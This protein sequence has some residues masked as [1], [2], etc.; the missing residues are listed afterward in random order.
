M[1]A[2]LERYKEFF[3]VTMVR[4]SLSSSPYASFEDSLAALREGLAGELITSG[5]P[6]FDEAR[7]M[8]AFTTERHP[9]AIV[10]AANE[11]DVAAAVNFAREH[12]L[13]LSVRS[14]GHSI[15]HLSVIDGAVV[16]DLSRM[17]G[18]RIDPVA[19]IGR[20]QAG[21]TSFDLAVP[22]NEHGLAL[23][24]GDTQ[25]VG[26]GG[27][28]TGGGIGFMV[29]KY[30]LAIDNLLSARVVLADG[31]IVTASPIERPDLF[32]A[33]RGGGGNVGIVT[34]FTY[35][36]A[37][38]GTILGGELMLPATREVLRGYL[39]YA[40][41]APEDLTTIANLVYA[42]PFPHV[43]ADRVGEMVLSILVVW[44]GSEEEGNRAL[45][46]LR[47]LAEPVADAIGMIPYPQIYKFTEHV[48]VRH[49][50][51]IRQMFAYD[52]SDDVVDAAL[53]AMK[54]ASS[55]F[56]L[57]QFRGLGGS[58]AQVDSNETAF[59][60]RDKTFFLAIIA[61]WLDPSEDRAAHDA[62]TLA[63]W[64][65]VRHEGSGVYVNF[66]ENE[67]EERIRQAYPA[68]TYARLA[69]IKRHYDPDNLFRFNQNIPPRQGQVEGGWI[70][71]SPLAPTG[72]KRDGAEQLIVSSTAD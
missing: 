66:L 22:A 71:D 37:P 50:A 13:P 55:P 58:M 35:R 28:T 15:A 64:E 3:M 56:S 60:H 59:A 19:R 40:A 23:S 33:I 45:A 43:P 2:V 18:V 21:A 11:Y 38:V 69:K 48:A 41:T 54:N 9:A 8:V 20:V 36:L 34:E 65:K 32:W 52:L 4:S 6:Q 16:V 27:L 72:A 63:L 39:D 7:H 46:P 51:A 1:T 70:E 47:A 42:P 10:R 14:G 53:D 5:S 57:I 44:T 61:V 12:G 49:G 29:R 24:T 31:S 67:G 17:K 25:S 68:L 30:G 26:M 62:W